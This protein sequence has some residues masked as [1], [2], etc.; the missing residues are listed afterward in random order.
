MTVA[1]SS[2]SHGDC[3]PALT[4]RDTVSLVL[5]TIETLTVI[6][7]AHRDDSY[8]SVDGRPYLPV[9]EMADD[10]VRVASTA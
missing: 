9:D 5:S 6:V 2:R 8:R 7:S 4:G 10:D 1:V 3:V